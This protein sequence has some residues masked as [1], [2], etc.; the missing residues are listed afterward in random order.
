MKLRFWTILKGGTIFE[1]VV[2]KDSSK[3]YKIIN[4]IIR[5]FS[6][7]YKILY[8]YKRAVQ[9]VEEKKIADRNFHARKI[10]LV[11][12]IQVQLLKLQIKMQDIVS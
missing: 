7:T 1:I 4:G 5:Q 10:H 9:A 6:R 3:M 8:S 2:P 11:S 12:K